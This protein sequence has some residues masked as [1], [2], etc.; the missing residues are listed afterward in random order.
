MIDA[1]S[2]LSRRLIAVSLLLLALITILNLVVVPLWQWNSD[3]LDD[4]ALART[5]LARMQA[6]MAAQ[7]PAKGDPVPATAMVVAGTRD[8][9]SATLTAAVQASAARAQITPL[10]VAPVPPLGRQAGKIAI[11]ISASGPE[12]NLVELLADIESSS[13]AIRLERWSVVAGDT[14]DLPAH[15]EARAVALWSARP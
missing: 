14:P 6:I 10:A 2:P 12:T 3:N 8:A 15:L 7:E 1:L 4:L 11:D 9:A 13:P 5:R